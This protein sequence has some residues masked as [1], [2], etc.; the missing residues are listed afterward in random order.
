[1]Y[2][3]YNEYKKDGYLYKVAC[4]KYVRDILAERTKKNSTVYIHKK[5]KVPRT[6]LALDKVK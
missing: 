1:M 4:Y 6:F 5:N 2:V 3:Q